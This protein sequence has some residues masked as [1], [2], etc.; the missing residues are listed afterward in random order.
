[1]WYL[2]LNLM[3]R[4]MVLERRYH[5]ITI[6]SFLLCHFISIYR[7]HGKKTREP[8]GEGKKLV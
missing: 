7:S 1:M 2:R 6:H 8:N 4:K 5:Y 3:L